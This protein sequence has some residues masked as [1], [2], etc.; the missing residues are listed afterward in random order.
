MSSRVFVTWAILAKFPTTAE[1]SY[2]APALLAAWSLT[3]V[4]RYSF[5]AMS[6][7]GMSVYPLTWLRYT[8]FIALYPLGVTGELLCAYSALGPVK[9][10]RPFSMALPN[11]WNF[12]FDSY[13]VLVLIMLL[14]VPIFPSLYKHMFMQRR[15]VLGGGADKKQA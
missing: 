4:V 12:T 11:T 9:K 14:Y 15:K 5:Y 1:T 6:L 7:V 13:V 8:L 2:G 3:E 10:E